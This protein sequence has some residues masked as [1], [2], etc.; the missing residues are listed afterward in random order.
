MSYR[1]W[2][3]LVFV[4]CLSIT[5][6]VHRKSWILFFNHSCKLYMWS[7]TEIQRHSTARDSPDVNVNLLGIS[8]TFDVPFRNPNDVTLISRTHVALKHGTVSAIKRLTRIYLIHL[9]ALTDRFSF[10]ECRVTYRSREIT[11]TRMRSSIATVTKIQN[12]RWRG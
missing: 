4:N 2:T 1:L 3:A 7:F 6:H 10:Q 12:G 9:T 11:S 5:I 8:Y